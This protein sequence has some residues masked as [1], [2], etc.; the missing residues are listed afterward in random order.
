MCHAGIKTSR[1]KNIPY[2]RCVRPE[3]MYGRPSESPQWSVHAEFTISHNG[4]DENNPPDA[5]VERE[6]SGVRMTYRWTSQTPSDAWATHSN[7]PVKKPATGKPVI[8]LQ[9][10]ARV[11]DSGYSS[12]LHSQ[13]SSTLP[14][15]QPYNRKCRSSC[16]IVL[17][18]A[19]NEEVSSDASQQC[20]RTQSLRCQTPRSETSETKFYGCGD[21][22]CY[23]SSELP[24]EDKSSASTFST[25]RAKS[26]TPPQRDVSVQT[27]EM[28][29][30]S[31]SPYMRSESFKYKAED[32]KRVA[33]KRSGKSKVERQSSYTP[34]SLESQK[35]LTLHLP[36]QFL[37]NVFFRV[38][39]D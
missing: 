22:W 28:V 27:L 11:Q 29:D 25:V 26:S 14:H 33:R 8:P 2:Q 38:L 13:G 4:A 7:H 36:H 9:R 32:G 18:T 39:D 3:E 19:I 6:G 35:V 34:D 24:S 20:G 23:H 21:P 30:K 31:T 15:P 16:S 37:M 1:F 12:E 5:R 10:T 17:S